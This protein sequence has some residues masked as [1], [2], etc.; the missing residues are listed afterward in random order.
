[1]TKGKGKKRAAGEGHVRQRPDGLWETRISIPGGK[2]KSFYGKTQAEALRKRNEFKAEYLG[3]G[4]DFDAE[5]IAFGEYLWRWLNDSYKA[6]V[7][8][9]TYDRAESL[10]RVHLEPALGHMRLSKLTGAHFQGLY[11]RKL[12]AGLSARSVQRIHQVSNTALKQAVKWRLLSSNPAE[13]ATRPKAEDPEINPLDREE[14]NALMNV[15]RGHRLEALIVTAVLSGLRAGELLG[16]RWK[17]VDF[18]AGI[19]RVRQQLVYPRSGLRLGPPK[20]DSSKRAVDVPPQVVAALRRRRAI[21]LEEKL[22]AGP[23]WDEGGEFKD[24]IFTRPNGRPLNPSTLTRRYL[25]PFL[26]EAGVAHKERRFHDLRHTFATLNLLNGEHVRVV[27]E[28][29]GH[30]T[31]AQTMN[32]YS[33]VLPSMGKSATR[34]LGELF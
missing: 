11:Q 34:W 9:R 12:D 29:L 21:Q 7:R 32:I 10:V 22:K 1:M 5:R 4:L 26:K 31:I 16:L 2:P 23:A 30:S 33:H 8:E 27:Q 15:V 19:L 28:A 24:L 13:N 18:E 20:R 25:T 17:D 3:G 6:S 14:A